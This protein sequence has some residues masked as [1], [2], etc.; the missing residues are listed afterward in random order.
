MADKKST[1]ELIFQGVDKTG[2]ATQSALRNAERFTGSLQNVTSPIRNVTASAVKLEAGLLAAGAAITTFA[3]K[4]AGDFDTAFREISTLIDQP[5]EDLGEF[6]QAILDYSTQSTKPLEEITQ[7]IYSAISAGVDY[8]D[9]IT[10]VATAEQLAV[11]GKA[12]LNET[13][14]VL[15]SSLNAYGLGMEEAERFSDALFTTVK[16]GQTTL[17][18]LGGALSQVT[19][20][21]ASAGVDF[22]E[23]LSAVAALTAAGAP[24]SQAVTQIRGALSNIIKPTSEAATLAAELGIDFNA[25]A[26]ESKGLA[27]VLEDV[28]RAT[29]GNTDEM[30]RLFGSVEALNGVLT[31]TGEGADAFAGTIEVMGDNTGATAA[32]F[33]KMADDIGN[34]NQKIA[35]ALRA[36]LV[37]VGQ[38]LLDEYQG[39]AEA[40]AAIFNAL[41]ANISTGGLGELVD[42]VEAQMGNLEKSLRNAAENLPEAL[43]LV[44]FDPVKDGI[45]A[46]RQAVD[47]LFGGI[48]L[49]TPEG[50]A[51]IIE[52]LGKAFGGL[53]QFTAGVIESFEPLVGL[54]IEMGGSA[55]EA[56]SELFKMVGNLA[57]IVSQ[58][59]LAIPLLNTLLGILI[60][61][62]GTGLA[63]ALGNSATQAG[64]F[65]RALGA[66]GLVA[67][68]GAG[69]YAVGTKLNTEI[70]EFVNVL[71]RSENTLGT[72][73][74]EVTHATDEAAGSTD[75]MADTARKSADVQV[76]SMQEIQDAAWE[77]SRALGE[78]NTAQEA[79][80]ERLMR[81]FNEVG[82]WLSGDAWGTSLENL[83]L[84]RV[85]GD[86]EEKTQQWVET[87]ENGVPTFQQANEVWDGTVKSIGGVD[88]AMED[89]AE[90]SEE[91]KI[92]MEELASNERIA[93]IE[94]NVQL[95]VAELEAQTRQVEA[96]FESINTTVSST[97]DLL[98]TLFSEYADAGF[99]EKFQMDR[100]ID[101]ENKRRQK[102]LDLQEKL[103]NA[104]VRALNAKAN[105][106]QSGQSL[107]QVDGAGLQPHLEAFMWE[108]LRTIQ[109]RVNED[110]LEM[111][112]GV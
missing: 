68:A 73:L 39:I 35:N 60:V 67:A 52:K 63:G 19:G 64:K 102:A 14:T 90:T 62:Q 38:P 95:N 17:P 96:A 32:A 51:N 10:A 89:A 103:T 93:N 94:A 15:V 81:S 7:A 61:K 4:A 3:V 69:G 13:L 27:G 107:I 59:D 101:L 57:G 33:E 87:T 77:R 44:D 8:S 104:Q 21:A 78:V 34:A 106:L 45:E 50:L 25:A 84:Y 105:A 1:V 97:G 2:A 91:F 58:V 31:L 40:I 108:I 110:G 66:G 42:Y 55:S 80:N 99:S 36:S 26:L 48:D 98:G 109:T 82:D 54:L 112:M 72:W 12:D 29:G 74:Y 16:Q 71:T 41:G 76:R 9:S 46:V 79:E 56:D 43:E 86:A 85:L 83:P 65:S 23:L 75:R 88:K 30:A 92:R 5:I 22:E 111:L 49:S 6:R 11:A 24:T 53:S 100:Q 70:N 37:E 20:L 28:Q 18:E 47:D